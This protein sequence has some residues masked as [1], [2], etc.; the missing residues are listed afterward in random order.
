MSYRHTSILRAALLTGV[1]AIGLTA[2][3]GGGDAGQNPPVMAPPPPPPPLPPPPAPP[4]PPPPA[5]QVDPATSFGAGFGAAFAAGP[6]DE[7]VDADTVNITPVSQ[8]ED[9]LDVPN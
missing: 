1:A 6:F 3:G 8:T 9:P 7:P 2:C 4:P 5:G